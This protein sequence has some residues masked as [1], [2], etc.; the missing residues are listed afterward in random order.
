M[1]LRALLNKNT[2]T[3]TSSATDVAALGRSKEAQ[4]AQPI[5]TTPTLPSSVGQKA[6]AHR[7]DILKGVEEVHV[8]LREQAQIILATEVSD[9]TK[10]QYE[11]NGVR[12]NASRSTGE[13]IDLTEFE[14]SASTYY[15]YR[16]SVR[17]HAAKTGLDAIKAYNKLMKLGNKDEAQAEWQKV[18]YAAADLKQYPTDKTGIPSPKAIA[19]GLSDPKPLSRPALAKREGRAS[20]DVRETKKLKAANAIA[21]KNPEW[22]SLLWNHLKNLDSHWLDQVAV[23]SL[24]GARPEELRTANYWRDGDNLKIGIEGAKVS[25]SKGQQWRIFTLRNDGSGEFSHLFNKSGKLAKNVSVPTGITDYPD[26]FS[27]AM[28][29]AGASVLVGKERMS[30]YVYRHSMASDLK[31]D[32][33]SREVIAMCLGHAVTRTQENYGRSY[34]GT[35]GKRLL[36]MECAK[37][38]K[39]THNTRYT[40]V[41]P[42]NDSTPVAFSTPAF[43]G[44]DFKL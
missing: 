2:V 39:V 11:R 9:K 34:G 35:K 24:T 38:I 19:L 7:P 29:R 44:L 36:S 20:T 28:A 21:K 4:S 37:E 13:P 14:G 32:G 15:A 27:K 12:L 5:A 22:R 41:A 40:A 10:E 18:L 16:A 8:W 31:A 6:K 30:G 43:D 25:D 33:A 17:Y 3:P 1:K 26:A 42:S 23:A